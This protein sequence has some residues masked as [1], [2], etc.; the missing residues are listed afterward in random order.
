MKEYP[1]ALRYLIRLLLIFALVAG[2]ILAK[3]LLVPLL[4][5]VLFAYLLYPSA[6]KFEQQ[7]I[8]RI[9][10]NFL[11]II[12]SIIFV[13]GLG[14]LF[15]ILISSFTQDFPE[16]KNELGK[17]FAD[18]QQSVGNIFGVSESQQKEMIKNL[19]NP[20]QFVG[21]FF[22]ATANTILTIGL[23]PVYTFL[24]LFYRNKFRKFISK[25]ATP[26]QEK[27]IQ[28]ILDQA[29][30][31]VPKYMKGLFVVCF[32]LMGMNSLGFYIIGVKY[33]LLLGVVAALFNFIPYLGT[34][35]GYILVF[36][37]VFATQ[38]PSL[39]LFVALQFFIVQF[40]ENNILTPNITGSYVQINPLVTILS[41]IA[42]GMI[43]GLPGMFIVIP[44]LAMLKII[45]ENVDSLKPV[46]YLLGTRGT[47]EFTPSLESIKER[48]TGKPTTDDNER[49]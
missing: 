39:A 22:T 25:L 38:S 8:P 3:T 41:L 24:L 31:I 7:N 48:F 45:C 12:G 15:A 46:G 40:L 14:F 36:L 42:A 20:A 10:T 47:E 32:I 27:P 44:Y 34:V 35:I 30:E 13:A 16:I 23:I 29:A 43:W 5:S 26:S 33:A 11:L 18:F 49:G 4:L 2:L 9:A 37:F 21:K 6:E 19:Q 1:V 17:N 28:N